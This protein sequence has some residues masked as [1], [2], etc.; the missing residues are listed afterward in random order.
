[1]LQ[2]ELIFINDNH[3][4]YYVK[5]FKENI[6]REDVKELFDNFY[7]TDIIIN[8]NKIYIM[9]TTLN[10]SFPSEGSSRS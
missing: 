1:L 8:D 3:K 6:R 9:G 7:A 2:D 5:Y 4:L 10:I